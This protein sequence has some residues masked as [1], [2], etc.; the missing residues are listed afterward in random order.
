MSPVIQLLLL[1]CLVISG[2]GAGEEEIQ[3][4]SIHEVLPQFGLPSGLFPNSVKSFSMD[5][6]NNFELKLRS[7]CT[8][9]FD[10]PLLYDSSIKG[11]FRY[12][13]IIELEGIQ[14]E[15]FRMSFEIT[16]IRVDLPPTK[17]IYFH[18]MFMLFE[19]SLDIDQFMTV[20]SCSRYV[21]GRLSQKQVQEV[22]SRVANESYEDA[23]E[24]PAGWEVSANADADAS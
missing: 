12:G 15:R 18:I 16:Q 6:D 24:K 1:T 11:T 10:Y 4:M 13:S 22:T 7:S 2:A 17:N 5:K 14:L 21:S 3:V 19:N 23:P 20:R 8:V 9:D